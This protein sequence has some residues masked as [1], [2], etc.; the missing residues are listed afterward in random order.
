MKEKTKTNFCDATSLALFSF[1][2]GFYVRREPARVGW[3]GGN[4]KRFDAVYIVIGCNTSRATEEKAQERRNGV[5]IAAHALL[6]K[7]HQHVG[8]SRRFPLIVQK[9]TRRLN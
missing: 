5:T 2:I 4:I 6:H 9:L 8:V 7:M 3:T 1:F